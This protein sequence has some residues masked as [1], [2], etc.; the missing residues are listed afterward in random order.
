[1]PGSD[2]DS[3]TLTVSRVVADGGWTAITTGAPAS[4]FPLVGLSALV[5]VSA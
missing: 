4:A 5:C 1:M 3:W 2:S